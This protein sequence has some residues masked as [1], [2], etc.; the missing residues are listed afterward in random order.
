MALVSAII[1]DA[2]IEIG[3]NYP[4]ETPPPEIQAMALRSLQRMIDGW[5]ADG[6]TLSRLLRTTFTLPSGTSSITIGPTG[7]VVLTDR[8]MSLTAA[9]YVIPGTSPSVESPIGVMDEDAYAAI[10]IKQLS[11]A[12]PLQCFYQTNLTDANGTLFFWPQVSQDVTIALYTPQPVAMPTTS[13]SVLIGPPGYADAFVYGLAMRL[14]NPCGVQMPQ[15]LPLLASRAEMVM[16]RP[17]IDPGQLSCD[18]ALVPSG[19]AGYNIL[20]DTMSSSRV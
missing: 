12:L 11:S 13:A 10:S 14:V 20:S 1:A 7:T 2:L 4:G 9:N 3:Y 19:G 5:G 8:P 15:A 6:L 17:N 16:K 18:P